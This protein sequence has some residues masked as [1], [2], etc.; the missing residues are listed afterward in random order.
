MRP[1]QMSRR[2][3]KPTISTRLADELRLLSG[4]SLSFT[5]AVVSK[6]PATVEVDL[7]DLAKWFA[8]LRVGAP[9]SP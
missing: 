5:L 4:C 2:C 7:T 9:W 8:R 6:R 3:S 1:L